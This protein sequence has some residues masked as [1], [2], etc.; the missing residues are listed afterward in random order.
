MRDR[1]YFYTDKVI[2]VISNNIIVIWW[3]IY[4]E[5][6]NQHWPSSIFNV[7]NR[8]K[9]NLYFS[10]LSLF[11][12]EEN[13]FTCCICSSEL[14]STL[15]YTF[16]THNTMYKILF[17]EGTSACRAFWICTTF[18]V[19]YAVGGINITEC[20]MRTLFLCEVCFCFFLF[21]FLPCRAHQNF[22][23]LKN[24]CPN[25]QYMELSS[26]E[27]ISHHNRN[28]R[29]LYRFPPLASY[30]LSFWLCF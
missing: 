3:T 16:C 10:A 23:V 12:C 22:D 28:K 1:A 29:G 13:N 21:F 26:K 9:K 19:Q 2:T 27:K 6:L 30:L 18:W 8:Q 15:F 25:P 14:N 7:G 4:H 24:F 20:V 17:C 11:N 5:M